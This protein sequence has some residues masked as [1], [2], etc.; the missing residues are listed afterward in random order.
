MGN[1]VSWF[2][3]AFP[4]VSRFSQDDIPD[5]AGKIILVTGGNTGIGYEITKCLLKHNAKVY[6]GCRS[7]EKARE[8][9]SRLREQ[10][11]LEA[12]FISLD[13][14]DLSSVKRAADEFKSKETELHVL[15]NN[16]GVMNPP[17]SEITADGFDLQF[18]T[19]VLGHFLLTRLLLP[20]LIAG[21]SSQRCPSRIVNSSSSSQMFVDT[22]DFNSLRDGPARRK[23][24]SFKLYMQSKFGNV[25]LSNE[26]ARRFGDQGI[27][28]NSLNPGNLKTD[29]Q[30]TSSGIMMKFFDY[31]VFYPPISGALTPL[32]AGVSPETQEWNG[33]YLI[34]WARE[35]HMRPEAADQK[36]GEELW[37]WLEEAGSAYI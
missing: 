7:E 36:L 26:L 30:R 35:G 11:G 33:K 21:A 15:F 4:P 16:G 10:T 27:R 6:I 31:W 29:L 37:N 34:P 8:A 28:S 22:V 12:L 32:Y 5:L 25:I 20:L 17:I 18:G 3:E 14:A 2:Q 1:I 13:L 9:I 19:N 23:M 24:G